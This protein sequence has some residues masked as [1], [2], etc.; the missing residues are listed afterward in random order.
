MKTV[1]FGIIGLGLMGQEFAS[2]A[3]RWFHLKGMSVRPEIIAICSRS[4]TSFRWFE[5]NIP[6]VRYATTDYRELLA[7]NEVDAIYCAVPNHLHEEI[8][9]AT[10]A[11]GKHLLGEKPFG[12]DRQA[13]KAILDVVQNHPELLVRCSSEFPFFPGAQKIGSL[14]EQ[15]AFGTVLEV[16][17]GFLHSSDLDP[18]KPINWKRMIPY[19]GEY[20]SMGDLG[21]HVLHIPYRAGWR[22]QNVRA[23]LSNIIT[24]RPDASG[25]KVPCETWDNATLLCETTAQHQALSFPMHLRFHRIAPGEKNSW[26]LEILG[27]KA[28]VRFNTR[29]PQTLELLEYKGEE[30]RWQS[31]ATGYETFFPAITGKIFEFGFS[32]AIL[33]MMAAYLYELQHGKPAG[34]FAHCVTPEETALSHQLFTAALESHRLKKTISL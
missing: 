28:S 24:E 27:T 8:Y 10:L 23:I 6:S 11:S 12:I 1:K 25:R 17:A 5:E 22:I 14:L 29:N 30:Q 34:R 31:V 33:Q 21:M 20:G 13:N 4:G 32:D 19:N 3:A 2:A 7:I 16:N 26:Y 18:Q 15:E 9:T